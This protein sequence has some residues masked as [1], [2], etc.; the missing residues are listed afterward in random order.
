MK[1]YFDILGVNENSSIE[2]IKKAYKKKAKEF[3]PDL[4]K[5]PDAE[6]HFKK[7]NEAYN[8]ILEYKNNPFSF[9][10][11]NNNFHNNF[12][13]NFH[14]DIFEFDLFKEFFSNPFFDDEF[15]FS[16]KNNF[17][18]GRGFRN[19][20]IN[21]I[22]LRRDVSLRDI[23]F[24]RTI[25]ITFPFNNEIKN[26]KVK[27]PKDIQNYSNT[28]VIP[29]NE[30]NV[31]GKIILFLNIRNFHGFKMMN[32]RD[33]LYN[34]KTENIKN[35]NSDEII[36]PTIDEKDIKVKIREDFDFKDKLRIKNK[37]LWYREGDDYKRGDMYISFSQQL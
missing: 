32:N 29:G 30:V 34:L 1:Q 33:L 15:M 8:K 21:E 35:K 11:R 14:R 16:R 7:I 19:F 27:I 25:E 36:V 17:D 26:L 20:T 24:G 22:H 12:R 18:E 23:F 3:H 10:R 37:G 5:S 6:E 4:N 31:P 9:Q 28:I 13:R 2:E